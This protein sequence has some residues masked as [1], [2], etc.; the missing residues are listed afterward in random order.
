MNGYSKMTMIE[1][2]IEK[3]KKIK[4]KKKNF[5]YQFKVDHLKYQFYL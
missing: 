1:R 2:W 5:S 4:K 3:E